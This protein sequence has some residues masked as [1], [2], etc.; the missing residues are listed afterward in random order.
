MVRIWNLPIELL[1]RQ[2]LLG[3]HAELHLAFITLVKLEKGVKAGWQHHP[4]V[5]RFKDHLGR[6]V[7]RH[8]Q[9]VREIERRG[10]QH[11]S[12]LPEFPYE[13]EDYVYSYDKLITDLGVLARR[14]GLYRKL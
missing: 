14:R 11:N 4:Q 5:L 9:Q 2:H 13:P 6:L 3:E 8:R 12:P 10:Y 7:T 1:D